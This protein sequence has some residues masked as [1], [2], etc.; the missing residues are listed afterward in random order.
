MA[1]AKAFNSPIHVLQAGTDLVKVGEEITSGRG[2]M[3]ISYH[4][5]MY[6]LGEVSL[7]FSRFS[8]LV[9]VDSVWKTELTNSCD[10]FSALQLVK[11]GL[12]NASF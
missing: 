6:G 2:P 3:L 9:S 4:R 12:F 8:S 1:L 7:L 11:T 5:K 10:I